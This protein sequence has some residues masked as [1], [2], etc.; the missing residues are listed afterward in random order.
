MKGRTAYE[1][2]QDVIDEICDDY[3]RY[4]NGEGHPSEDG[5]FE[6]CENCPFTEMGWLG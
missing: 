5:A 3:C 4:A 6:E 2:I 1:I